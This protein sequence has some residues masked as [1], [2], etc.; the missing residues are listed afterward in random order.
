MQKSQLLYLKK[1]FIWRFNPKRHSIKWAIWLPTA[2]NISSKYLLTSIPKT[3]RHNKTS[4]PWYEL[5]SSKVCEWDLITWQKTLHLFLRLLIGRY[6]T[7]SFLPNQRS[8]KVKK[9]KL[10]F[11]H[12]TRSHLYTSLDQSSYPRVLPKYYFMSFYGRNP[13]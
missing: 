3:I 6:L 4:Y 8:G 2:Y 11:R 1:F 13:I 9:S 5:L 10:I 12:V 7:Q